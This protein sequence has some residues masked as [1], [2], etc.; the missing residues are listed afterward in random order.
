VRSGRIC[1]RR[2]RGLRWLKYVEGS[3][4]G[5]R[6]FIRSLNDNITV[7]DLEAFIAR[8]EGAAVVQQAIS[9]R[10]L[11]WCLGLGVL[12]IALFALRGAFAR[13]EPA[14]GMSA[15]FVTI[16]A[17]CA[18]IGAVVY[19]I[20]SGDADVARRAIDRMRQQPEAIAQALALAETAPGIALFLRSFDVEDSGASASEVEA[21]VK[22]WA[23]L[24]RSIR[25]QTQGMFGA[26]A[27]DAGELLGHNIWTSQLEAIAAVR[28]KLPVVLFEN[29]T[30]AS[31][32]REE[33][34]KL[35]VRTV[36]VLLGDWWPVLLRVAERSRFAVFFLEQ[37]SPALR[38]EMNQFSAAPPCPYVVIGAT[39]G[40]DAD[41]V[42]FLAGSA[43]RVV[44]TD[45][46]P[47]SQWIDE[48]I[49][50]ENRPQE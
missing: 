6:T 30:T 42:R 24:E 21:N 18:L 12:A 37:I 47:L 10:W 15:L 20:E 8:E 5:F 3:A 14:I 7:A 28:A 43:L 13:F 9:G 36:P 32:K 11:I 27:P 34:E 40:Q 39:D 45:L 17:F 25:D 48:K 41:V 19:G 50:P 35:D 38:R 31:S 23:D 33:L 22:Y 49:G 2:R 44:A 46:A 1:P 4:T 29:I 16:A 26:P